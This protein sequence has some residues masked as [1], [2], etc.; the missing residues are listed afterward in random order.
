M[1]ALKTLGVLA[2]L[3][4]AIAIPAWA[5][6]DYTV[7]VKPPNGANDT[8][9]LQGALDVCVQQHPTGC[10]VQLAA[11][12][13]LTKQLVAYNFRGTFKGMG[14]DRTTIEA[15]HNLTVTL[16][17]VFVQGECRPNNTTCLWP[18]LIIFVDGD[19]QVSD[20]SIKI[21]APP[22]T[23]T[24]GWI[25]GGST[26]TGLIDALRFNGQHPTNVCID[27]IAVE[28]LPDDSPTSFG[29]NVINGVVYSGELPRSTTP[30]DYYFM[31]GTL[32]VRNSS[33]KTMWDGVSQAGFLKDTRLTVGGSPS[34]GNVFENLNVGIDLEASETSVFEISHNMSSG[35][36]YSMWVV[37]WQPVF[38]PSKPSQYF[39][40][41][42]KF[43]TTGP[44]AGGIYLWND[45][46]N[47]WIHAMIY[48]NTV[49][50]QDTLWDGIGAY[51]TKGSAIWNNTITGNGADAIGLYGSTLGTVISNNVSDF[52]ADPS[53]EHAQIYLDPATS[54]DLVVCSDRHDTVLNQGTMNKVIGCQDPATAA[55]AATISADPTT[56]VTQPNVPRRKPPLP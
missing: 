3:I 17:D 12:K 29:F 25:F 6:R 21:T 53:S 11:G 18:S 46:T 50:P 56:S 52:T 5:G 9:A 31:S 33:F 47:P 16:G 26:Y 2:C 44:Q 8:A 36:L 24:A 1:K 37:P 38:V 35:I 40:H 42:N 55:E 30:F 27:R 14:K 19:I 20:L 7:Y 51:N 43:T 32:T 39:I 45:P 13:Y 34:A 22:G 41:D 54:Y 4:L 49:E 10:T 23:A 48:N 15:L 28:G